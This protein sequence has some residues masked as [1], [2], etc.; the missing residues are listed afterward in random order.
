MR[1]ISV[2]AAIAM[3]IASGASDVD[4]RP[5]S[6]P[7][8]S[9]HWEVDPDAKGPIQVGDK[10][11]HSLT[12]I[13]RDGDGVSFDIRT[14][15]LIKGH[16]YTV[17]FFS[18]DNPEACMSSTFT[19]TH[20]GRCSVGDL[21]FNPAALGS[22]MWGR[23]GKFV[24]TSGVTR[25]TG[26]R[27]R[28]AIP[29]ATEPAVASEDCSG[30]LFGRGLMNPLKAEV[31]FVLRDHGPDQKDVDDETSTINGGCDPT[32]NAGIPLYHAG[33]GTP[34]NFACYDPQGN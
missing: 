24:K 8:R 19:E 28:N 34:G 16:G 10:V 17:W 6:D 1:W 20:G 18:Y 31:H 23:A 5:A 13:Y 21:L 26:R 30:V 2:I 33:W 25:F 29:C 9:L 14:S 12:R 4:A 7:A 22:L 11:K 15:R 32:K 27:P 3:L